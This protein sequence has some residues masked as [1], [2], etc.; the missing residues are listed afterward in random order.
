MCPLTESD[1]E[2]RW[3]VGPWR[4][5]GASVSVKMRKKVLDFCHSRHWRNSETRAFF[6]FFF[7]I[8]ISLGI[9]FLFF[10]CFVCFWTVFNYIFKALTFFSWWRLT[11]TPGP[12]RPMTPSVKSS[13]SK[14][15]PVLSAHQR[16]GRR[17]QGRLRQSVSLHCKRHSHQPG[18]E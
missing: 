12:P 2:I 3:H 14:V 18:N 16:V 13:F 8:I 9:F 15:T 17:V 7:S 4:W 6:V 11:S 5:H 1:N 10:V